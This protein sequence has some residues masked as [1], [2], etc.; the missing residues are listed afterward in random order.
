MMRLAHQLPCRHDQPIGME[1]TQLLVRAALGTRSVGGLQQIEHCA[2]PGHRA[3]Q[4]GVIAGAE[5]EAAARLPVIA[6]GAADGVEAREEGRRLH[7][8]V[9][10][11]QGAFD[12]VRKVFRHVGCD[13]AD[14]GVQ[15][16]MDGG[17]VGHGETLT[18]VGPPSGVKVAD[19]AGWRTKA[20]KLTGRKGPADLAIPTHRPPLKAIGAFSLLRSI[21]QHPVSLFVYSRR[22]SRPR[23]LASA[24][25]SSGRAITSVCKESS[26]PS[27]GRPDI[28]R[29][30]PSDT[31]E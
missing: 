18:G 13:V 21:S 28:S 22:Q 5:G 26:Q 14:Q 24:R 4:R 20:E 3:A 27:L 11:L 7:G 17:A 29:C 10:F 8:Q 30:V 2:E 15:A 12:L 16:G 9:L 1:S 6:V 25:R 23:R 19:G 31:C